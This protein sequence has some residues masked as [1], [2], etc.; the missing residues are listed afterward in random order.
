MFLLWL[1]QLPRY[2]DQ[3]PALVPPPVEGRSSPTNTLVFPP[4][5]FVLPTSVWFHI[6]FFPLLRYSCPL[7]AGVLHV[8]LCLKMYSWCIYGERCTPHPPTPLPCSFRP[9]L[10]KTP[11]AG[12]Q[13]TS[14]VVLLKWGCD[15]FHH[16]LYSTALSYTLPS[17]PLI[18]PNL[19]TVFVVAYLV[20]ILKTRIMF[21]IDRIM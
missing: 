3:T 14:C 12:T 9:T 21:R 13:L 18:T 16:S 2:G 7:S 19:S 1:R 15:L 8:V 20:L 5:S 4:S 17:F 11:A 6:F 10:L